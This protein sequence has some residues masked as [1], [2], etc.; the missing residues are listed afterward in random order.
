MGYEICS[1]DNL[2]DE[3]MVQSLFSDKNPISSIFFQ[4]SP[5]ND[6]EKIHSIVWILK[7]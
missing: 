5:K 2:S 6:G 7:F 4:I 3:L 1:V